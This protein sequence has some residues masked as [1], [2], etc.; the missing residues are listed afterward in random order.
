M[1][2]DV[3][4]EQRLDQVKAAL[5]EAIEVHRRAGSRWADALASLRAEAD[6][7]R[8]AADVLRALDREWGRLVGIPGGITDTYVAG[9]RELNDRIHRSQVSVGTALSAGARWRTD[10]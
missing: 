2:D 3:P 6:D 9:E 1:S 4:A 5:D 8:P 7:D 10:D